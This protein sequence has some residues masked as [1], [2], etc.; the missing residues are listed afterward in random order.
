MFLADIKSLFNA[1]KSSLTANNISDDLLYSFDKEIQNLADNNNISQEVIHVY[2][3]FVSMKQDAPDSMKNTLFITIRNFAKEQTDNQ[4]YLESLILY[5][6]LIVKSELIPDDYLTIA[7][8][9]ARLEIKN[10]ALGFANLYVKKETNKALMFISLANF[11]NLLIKDYKTAIK[12]YEKYLEIDKTKSVVYTITANLYAKAYG[13]ESIKEQLSYWKKAYKLKPHDRL[14]LHGLAFGYE[15][16]GDK[17]KAL[18]YYKELLQ[19]NPTN[20]DYFNY[21]AFMISCGDFQEGH[22]YFRYRFLIDDN[23]YK[24]P[25]QCDDNKKWD[26][27]TDISDKTLLVHYEQGFGDTIMYCRFVPQLKNFAQK[28]IFVVQDNLFELIKNSPLISNDIEIISGNTDLSSI[29][30]D[31]NMSLL[32]AP[33]V[34]KTKTSDIPFCDKNYID[35]DGQKIKDYA[36]NYITPSSNL[37]IGISYNGDKNANYNDRNIDLNKFNLLTD[38]NNIDFYSLQYDEES[39]NPKI[40][41]LGKSFKNFTDTAA[42]IKNM[43]IIISTDNVILNLAGALG[44]KTIGLFNKQTNYRWFKGLNTQNAQDKNNVGWYE[45]IKPLQTDVQNNWTPIFIELIK[46]L[47]ENK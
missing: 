47:T 38:I 2:S 12:Y 41:S 16:L 8:N 37:K 36:K 18:Q 46:I 31:Y 20:I 28:I 22:K 40:K 27:E 24:Y 32:D 7:E 9:L 14:I 3:K 25:I 35:I 34:L 39:Q 4:K 11:Y 23:N 42:A 10:I 33:Y 17:N 1:D 5:R 13:D 6:F 30:Y 45:S 15:K 43:D 26:L 29:E 19:N 21:G 44:V